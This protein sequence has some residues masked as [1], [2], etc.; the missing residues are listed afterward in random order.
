MQTVTVYYA[1]TCAFSA[2]T[3]SFLVLRGADFRVLNLEEHPDER[4]RLQEKLD[5]KLETPTL[6]IGGR[7]HVAPPLSDLKKL[8]I[9]AGL[10]DAAAPHTKLKASGA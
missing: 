4:A 5:R 6:D 2:G 10:P 9:E 8:L 1:P 3:I 7:L